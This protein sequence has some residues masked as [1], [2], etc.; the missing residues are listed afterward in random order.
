MAIASKRF[1]SACCFMIVFSICYNALLL[2][3]VYVTRITKRGVML[4][5]K[6]ASI[7]AKF[8]PESLPLPCDSSDFYTA[9][10]WL[11]SFRKRW[12]T[13]EIKRRQTKRGKADRFVNPRDF[14]QSLALLMCCAWGAVVSGVIIA[15]LSLSQI[16]TPREWLLTLGLLARLTLTESKNHN[17]V[18]QYLSFYSAAQ[19]QPSTSQQYETLSTKRYMQQSIFIHLDCILA[20]ISMMLLRSGDVELNPGPPKDRKTNDSNKP[21]PTKVFDEL[22][23][24]SLSVSVNSKSVCSDVGGL[25][26]CDEFM[27]TFTT[28][29]SDDGIQSMGESDLRELDHTD[30]IIDPHQ[31]ESD[32]MTKGAFK[33][34]ENTIDLQ[35]IQP[36]VENEPEPTN[37]ITFTHKSG[38]TRRPVHYSEGVQDMPDYYEVEDR[39][40]KEEFAEQVNKE[41]DLLVLKGLPNSF[42]KYHLDD[43]TVAFFGHANRLYRA[44]CHCNYCSICGRRKQDVATDENAS[45]KYDSHIF[46]KGIL[47][48]FR[49]IHC[50]NSSRASDSPKQ[51][52]LISIKYTEFIYDFVLDERLGTSAWTYELHCRDCEQNCSAAEQKLRDVYVDL[53]GQ[54]ELKSVEFLNKNYWFQFILAIIMFRGL[55]VS[56]KLNNCF[57]KPLFKAGFTE[58]WSFCKSVLGA[59]KLRDSKNPDLMAKFDQILKALKIPDL[60]LF[61]LPNRQ[62]S[63]EKAAFLYSFEY[64]LRCPMF[65]RLVTSSENGTFL[66]WKFDCF[67]VVLPLDDISRKYFDH[68]QN[69][70]IE[71]PEKHL[72][73]RWTNWS[74]SSIAERSAKS[75]AIRIRY[76]PNTT[77]QLFPPVLLQENAQLRDEVTNKICHLASV[78]DLDPKL[79]ASCKIMTARHEGLIGH[80]YPFLDTSAAWDPKSSYSE[81]TSPVTVV[82]GKDRN[83]DDDNKYIEKAV[84]LSPL[85]IT[86]II[87]E[88]ESENKQLKEK[89][90]RMNE[91]GNID[92]DELVDMRSRMDKAEADLVKEKAKIKDKQKKARKIITNYKQSLNIKDKELSEAKAK[93]AEESQRADREAQRVEEEKMKAEEE[94]MEAEKT[95]SLLQKQIRILQEQ[96]K[97]KDTKHSQDMVRRMGETTV[98]NL[99]ETMRN[100]GVRLPCQYSRSFSEVLQNTKFDTTTKAKCTSVFRS[101]QDLTLLI[102]GSKA[103]HESAFTSMEIHRSITN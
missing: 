31:P 70:L 11:K 88:L 19:V 87:S 54:D 17:H 83:S 69:I 73:L 52:P 33:P 24:A 79:L 39:W 80:Q 8:T 48:V 53:M 78:A 57:N 72:I 50:Y 85:Q 32:L 67:H 103:N 64:I 34:F 56:E 6:E 96:L 29:A 66:Y 51:K 42:A 30:S 93:I 13:T 23:Q 21:E 100:K 68:F 15:V 55:L 82:F 1:Y 16:N 59:L 22:S 71:S 99:M 90:D 10:C 94:K 44:G 77:P 38:H 35:N 89:V 92:I 98:N 46:S 45:G 26:P 101:L 95:I 63:K 65:T 58:L 28:P 25:P 36:Q 74:T 27:D 102:A 20:I 86:E 91:H 43:C 75:D 4:S 60:R 41:L 12:V 47:T 76:N 9:D 14:I 3:S 62:I 97:E 61:L 5:S 81:E 2:K 49:R 7:P 84:C 37:Y 18:H 40:K